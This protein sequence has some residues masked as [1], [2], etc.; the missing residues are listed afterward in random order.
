MILLDAEPTILRSRGEPIVFRS[1]EET[2]EY[3]RI[4][5]IQRWKVYGDREGWWP[6]YRLQ[7]QQ[8]PLTPT[9]GAPFGELLAH[10]LERHRLVAVGQVHAEDRFQGGHVAMDVVLGAPA[11]FANDLERITAVGGVLHFELHPTAGLVEHR[12]P[13]LDL[14]ADLDAAGVAH[15]RADD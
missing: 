8:Q 9:A 4:H 6:I 7:R 1:P 5:G 13:L 12:R 14:L 15:A 2:L 3:A 11:V 10:V